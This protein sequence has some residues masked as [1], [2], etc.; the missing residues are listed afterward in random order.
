MMFRY[1]SNFEI[2]QDEI[3]LGDRVYTREE[4]QATEENRE[5]GLLWENLETISD[6]EEEP[7]SETQPQP[8]AQNT[9]QRALGKRRK[10]TASIL[11][12]EDDEDD[13]LPPMPVES[14]TQTRMA[15]RNRGQ[16][17]PRRE[18]EDFVLY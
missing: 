9:S 11:D 12:I 18:D 8:V 14:D 2:K 1:I 5:A 3:G 16:K 10:S 6:D 13:Q 17:R 7:T 15:T 4:K